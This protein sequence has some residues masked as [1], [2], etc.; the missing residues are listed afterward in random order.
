MKSPSWIPLAITFACAWL[1][2]FAATA[3]APGD[4]QLLFH[5]GGSG[6]IAGIEFGLPDRNAGPRGPVGREETNPVFKRA[7]AFGCSG[8]VEFITRPFVMPTAP[9]RLN[10]DVLHGRA[11]LTQGAYVMVEVVNEHGR[12][13]VGF[14]RAKSLLANINALDRV[15]TWSSRN[16]SGLAGMRVAL[17][18][19]LRDARLYSIHT[20]PHPP[21][22]LHELVLQVDQPAL[23]SWDPTSVTVL[24]RG[25][26]GRLVS[27]DHSALSFETSAPETVIVRPDKRDVHEG[28]LT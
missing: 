7:S 11:A 25:R 8:N 19:Y 16:T 12:V 17:R 28:R 22:E 1:R 6:A 4:F 26:D 2:G 27:L 14:E 24:G 15:L 18:F 21:A 3:P 13:I 23:A 5:D 10:I 20:Q 9:L